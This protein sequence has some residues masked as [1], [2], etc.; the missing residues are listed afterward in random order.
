MNTLRN[1]ELICTIQSQTAA[2]EAA[3]GLWLESIQRARRAGVISAEDAR[4][5]MRDA[6]AL[7]A[8]R[9]SEVLGI[10]RKLAE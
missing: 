10:V 3:A 9:S 1:N 7:S 5:L 6:L 2:D 8:S 4:A